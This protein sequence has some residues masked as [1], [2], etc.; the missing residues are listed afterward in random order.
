MLI[1]ASTGIQNKRVVLYCL[2]FIINENI[3]IVCSLLTSIDP[4][5]ISY[6]RV[7]LEMIAWV[8]KANMVYHLCVLVYLEEMLPVSLM[9][10][11]F[12]IANYK[13]NRPETL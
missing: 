11:H 2:L 3:K 8:L 5:G 4:L 10:C 12:V 13:R 1:I 7:C 6:V 9:I